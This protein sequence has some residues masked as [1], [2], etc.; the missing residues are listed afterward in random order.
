M[1]QSLNLQK[2]FAVSL[3][4]AVSLCGC[5]D[6]APVGQQ[7][8]SGVWVNQENHIINVYED[9]TATFTIPAHEQNGQKVS[10]AAS[11]NWV[12]TDSGIAVQVSGAGKISGVLNQPDYF[13]GNISLPIGESVPLNLE[14]QL[15]YVPPKIL[16]TTDGNAFTRQ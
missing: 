1:K 6:S 12:P 14:Y 15:E 7:R 2:A 3:L 16:R 13:G 9:G 4:T 5:N 11:G 8:F 10:A